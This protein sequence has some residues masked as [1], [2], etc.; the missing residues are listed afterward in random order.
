MREEI[1]VNAR[2]PKIPEPIQIIIGLWNL[3][4]NKPTLQMY[5]HLRI[6]HQ[7]PS[8]CEK[9]IILRIQFLGS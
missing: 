6:Y 1:P 3:M 2:E 8:K 7:L 9:A 4:E 5:F